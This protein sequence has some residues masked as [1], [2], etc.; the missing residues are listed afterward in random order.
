MVNVDVGKEAVA[1]V[2]VARIL[3]NDFDQDLIVLRWIGVDRK[4]AQ[5]RRAF[6]GIGYGVN[7]RI[8]ITVALRP[9]LPVTDLVHRSGAE[10]IPVTR[11]TLEGICCLGR[12]HQPVRP[13][14]IRPV[15]LAHL[16]V[17]P[18]HA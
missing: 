9:G 7:N 13:N 15:A 1:G 14:G 11:L 2:A 10:V 8:R 5:F 3:H 18:V 17:I 4:D 16:D 6:A 12:I